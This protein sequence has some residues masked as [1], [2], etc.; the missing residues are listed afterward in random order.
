MSISAISSSLP[1]AQ[2]G[3]AGQTDSDH[4]SDRFS[5]TS[6]TAS[7]ANPWTTGPGSAGPFQQLTASLQNM[8]LQVQSGNTTT[9]SATQSGSQ[10]SAIQTDLNTLV[11]DLAQ[12]T[13]DHS[14]ATTAGTPGTPGTT[15]AATQSQQP[16]HHHHH[17]SADSSGSGNE[18]SS[19]TQSLAATLVADITQALRAYG[20]STTNGSSGFT[21]STTTA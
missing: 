17:A 18:T 9:S 5:A 4:D 7:G 16:H 13:Q 3:S 10:P 2:T 8:L 15:T 11:N 21:P 19:P 6:A 14:G 12:S 20:T 1:W